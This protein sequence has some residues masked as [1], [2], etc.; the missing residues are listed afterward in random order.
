MRCSGIWFLTS[1]WRAAVRTPE[2]ERYFE[3][4][5]NC[6]VKDEVGKHEWGR[7]IIRMGY[8]EKKTEGKGPLRVGGWTILK[9]ILER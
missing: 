1:G 8:L 4:L 3:N 2:N 5:Y 9:W 7:R 6:D